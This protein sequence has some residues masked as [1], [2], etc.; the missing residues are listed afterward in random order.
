[1]CF[2][3]LPILKRLANCESIRFA[4]TNTKRPFHFDVEAF[5]SNACHPALAAASA[6]TTMSTNLI[7]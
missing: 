7:A 4:S 1:M 5:V 3:E 2:A 6:A